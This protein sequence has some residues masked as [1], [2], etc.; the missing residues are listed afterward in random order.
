[1]VGDSLSLYRVAARVGV[2]Q[3][4]T[5][6]LSDN[7]KLAL[8]DRILNCISEGLTFYAEVLRQHQIQE[9]TFEPSFKKTIKQKFNSE[10]CSK[11]P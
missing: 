8:C 10:Q 3:L 9:K 11:L 6:D 5:T 4:T 1:L 7:I 2:F